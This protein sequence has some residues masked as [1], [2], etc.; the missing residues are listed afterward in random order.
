MSKI[1]E[2]A[3][4]LYEGYVKNPVRSTLVAGLIG[5]SGLTALKDNVHFVPVGTIEFYKPE[6][7]QYV[8]GIFP[9]A[10]IRGAS[11]DLGEVKSITSFG[12]IAPNTLEDS[13]YARNM[14]AYGLFGGDN[15][16]GNYSRV[17]DMNAYALFAGVN[18]VGNYSRVED[19]NAY[20]LLLGINNVGNYSRVED[21]NA[22]SLI[23]G[24]NDV[25]NNS[26]VEDMDA[27]GLIGGVNDVGNGT[28]INGQV[29]SRGLIS[30]TP[31]GKSL[32]ARI[33]DFRGR[34][35]VHQVKEETK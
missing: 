35:Y 29:N 26:R 34:N 19:M 11:K 1:K 30:K 24:V 31:T 8:W 14:N 33:G 7:N 27:Y 15:Y 23:G 22:Y 20:S 10:K 9:S 13:S 17:E 21:M 6:K 4:K 2:L 5:L 32:V 12:F 3:K 16:V 25:G 28:S 18:N